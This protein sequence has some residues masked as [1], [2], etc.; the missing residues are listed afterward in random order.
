M[1]TLAVA[2]GA[3]FLGKYS[4]VPAGALTFAI[5][6]VA[7]LNISTGTAYLHKNLKLIAQCITGIIVGVGVTM[8]DVL[9]MGQLIRPVL[10][11]TLC[12]FLC[13]Y[14][15]AFLMHKVCKLDISTS[16]YG[17]IPAGV[18]DMALIATD[19]G[20]DAP[21]V[22]VLQLI[23]YIGLFSVMPSIIQY[24]TH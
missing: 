15:C 22:S 9:S 23:R 8:Q 20:G 10:I 18:S 12:T 1:P 4:G 2:E 14:V 3:G 17:S 21:K 19:L 5:L 24:L 16:L 6:A 13:N 7:A 11:L